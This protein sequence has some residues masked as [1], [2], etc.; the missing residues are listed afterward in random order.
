MKT[1]T[2]G[3]NPK[4]KTI[5]LNKN[6]KARQPKK[7]KAAVEADVV[8]DKITRIIAHVSGIC[9]YVKENLC[10]EQSQFEELEVMLWDLAK[11]GPG[12]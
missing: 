6:G 3:K 11:R 4:M 8:A 2:I 9:D 10:S 5:R 12:R 7:T 1:I